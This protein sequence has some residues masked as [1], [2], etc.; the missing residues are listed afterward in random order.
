MP[1][2]AEQTSADSLTAFDGGA[3]V[4]EIRQMRL[5]NARFRPG[6]AHLISAEVPL[7]LYWQQYAN[8]E[9]PDRNAGSRGT[10]RVLAGGPDTLTIECLG[11]TASGEALSRY[12]LSLQRKDAGYVYDIRAELRIAAQKSWLVTPNPHHGELEFCNVWPAGAFAADRQKPLRYRGCYVLHGD[13]TTLI[14]HHHL[15]SPDKHNILLGEGDRIAWLLEDENPVIEILPGDPVTAGVC[16]YMWD[17]HLAVKSCHDGRAR[18][19]PEGTVVRA[20]V[21]LSAM[22]RGEATRIAEKARPATTAES[23]R[24][25]IIVDGI[26]T[27]AETLA[28]TREN[29]ADVWP[30]E[31]ETDSAEAR[32]LVDRSTGYDDQV[33]LCIASSEVVRAAWKATALGPAFRQKP[34]RDGDRLSASGMVRTSLSRGAATIALR[35]HREGQPGLFDPSSYELYRSVQRADTGEWTRVEVVTPPLSPPPDRV[36]ILLELNGSGRCWFDN[37]HF[38][39]RR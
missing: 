23:S 24:V 16:A 19:L 1:L 36:H 39:S 9:D 5:Q 14:P 34:F 33:S 11:A 15:E 29:P 17:L 13:M 7:P 38:L 37:V 31:T 3:P 32:F 10:L 28:T 18:R 2:S 26:H 35:L 20:H 27:F 25:P 22:D 8:H 4:F 12:I 6:G 30:W 21:A